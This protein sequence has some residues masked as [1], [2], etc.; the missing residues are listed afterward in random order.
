M[1][2]NKTALILGGAMSVFDEYKRAKRLCKFSVVIGVNDILG[3]VPE[4]TDF[5][6][7]HPGKIARWLDKRRE[8]GY[9][10]PT[11]YWTSRDRACQ[12]PKGFK[13][14][15]LPNTRGGSGL[16]A[17]YVARHLGC[18]KIV[19]AGIPMTISGEHYHTPGRWKECNLYRIVWKANASLKTDVRSFGGWTR[20]N[21]GEPSRSWLAEE[22]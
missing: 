2:G 19:L 12:A 9:P 20:D 16:L 8:N 17:I 5:V 21:Y 6:S 7:M 10:D 1:T 15:T 18:N 11:T 4:I 22:T 3:E 14:E 13:F